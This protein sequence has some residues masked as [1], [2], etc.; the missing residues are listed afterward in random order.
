[1]TVY[2]SISHDK[3]T[4]L[5]VFTRAKYIEYFTILKEF[6]IDNESMIEI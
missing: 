1:M 6:F 5:N 4:S 3:F 2:E